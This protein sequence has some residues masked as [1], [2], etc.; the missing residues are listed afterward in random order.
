MLKLDILI[1]VQDLIN[2]V[3]IMAKW[4]LDFVF[5]S[6]L[7]FFQEWLLVGTMK[8]TYYDN[9]LNNFWFVEPAQPAV[10]I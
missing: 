1:N 5:I 4:N 7:Y 2:P 8:Q 9:F 3:N 6:Q 10:G